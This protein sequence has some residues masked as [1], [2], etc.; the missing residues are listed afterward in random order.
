MNSGQDTE[1]G[2]IVAAD[3]TPG[4]ESLPST[5]VVDAEAVLAPASGP[6]QE[7]RL[8]YRAEPV[9]AVRE[10]SP[11]IE[12][13]YDEMQLEDGGYTP[14][15]VTCMPWLRVKGRIGDA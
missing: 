1:E 4:E 15:L 14:V 11:D 3:I 5:V 9:C 8:E 2:E 12:E 10:A 6:A 13:L 7:A